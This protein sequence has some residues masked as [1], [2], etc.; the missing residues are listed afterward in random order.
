[1]NQKSADP[2]PAMRSSEA[3]A[4]LSDLRSLRRHIVEAW[5]SRSVVLTAE[6]RRE[7]TAEIRETCELLAGLT[8]SER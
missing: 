5:Q 3:Q 8:G 7:L 4:I 2:L 1:M 6:E